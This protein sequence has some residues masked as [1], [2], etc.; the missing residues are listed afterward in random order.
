MTSLFL[1]ILATFACSGLTFARLLV[2]EARNMSQPACLCI[3]KF[4][5]VRIKIAA[6]FKTYLTQLRA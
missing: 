5:Q 6:Y 2:I 4:S 1:S 3:K